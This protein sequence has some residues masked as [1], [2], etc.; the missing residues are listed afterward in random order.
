MGVECKLDE[1]FD[2]LAIVDS[3]RCGKSLALAAVFFARASALPIPSV[4]N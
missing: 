3:S 1:R 4:T 2:L